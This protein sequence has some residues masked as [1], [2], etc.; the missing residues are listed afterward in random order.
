MDYIKDKKNNGVFGSDKETKTVRQIYSEIKKYA[1]RKKNK[2][3][4]EF[5]K[6]FF[7]VMGFIDCERKNNFYS[8]EKD[9]VKMSYDPGCRFFYHGTRIAPSP[10]A[11]QLK[12]GYEIDVEDIWDCTCDEET[13]EE[14]KDKLI[15][16]LILYELAK[17]LKKGHDLEKICMPEY[18]KAMELYIAK[19]VFILGIEKTERILKH[20]KPRPCDYVF[21]NPYS[22]PR[23]LIRQAYQK[24]EEI[25]L[26]NYG[27]SAPSYYKVPLTWNLEL[28]SEA[29]DLNKIARDIKFGY[30]MG[31]DW[32]LNLSSEG[33]PLPCE[34]FSEGAINPI[35]RIICSGQIGVHT[36]TLPVKQEI[37]DRDMGGYDD[38]FHGIQFKILPI[39]EYKGYAKH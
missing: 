37:W 28:Y 24:K 10:E 22:F 31:K 29:C 26:D 38:E 25:Y 30:Q 6:D 4:V 7:E 39:F 5:K 15:A 21:E 9:E 8:Y 32:Y 35:S 20:L 16:V 36:R 11:D 3:P 18:I 2:L 13:E 27:G 1:E 19:S 23:M 33:V 14:I 12:Y 34:Y 17:D